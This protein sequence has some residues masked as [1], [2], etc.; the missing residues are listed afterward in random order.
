MENAQYLNR[1]STYAVGNEIGC[2]GND[3][4]TGSRHAA[5][6]THRRMGAKVTDRLGYERDHPGGGI[7]IISRDEIGF[8][9]QVF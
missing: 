5:R 2:A 9:F 6:T 4:F 7:R 8:C 3:Q 1:L